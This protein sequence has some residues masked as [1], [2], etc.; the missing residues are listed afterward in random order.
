[1]TGEDLF[2]LVVGTS[3]A[4]VTAAAAVWIVVNIIH[5]LV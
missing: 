1:M 4:V 5:S 3:I 2:E